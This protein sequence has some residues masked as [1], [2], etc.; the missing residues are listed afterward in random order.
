MIFDAQNL[1]SQAQALTTTAASTNY[2]NLSQVR[3][4]G[5]GEPL[6]L[7]CVVTTA[8]TDTGSDS[9][10]TVALEGDS[11]T[12]FTPDGTENQFIFP[13]L[14]AVGAT[15]ITR[16]DPG[17]APLQYQYIQLKYTMTGGDLT[18]GA[19]TAFLTHDIDKY[20]SY[21]KGYTIS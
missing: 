10:V 6:Y 15:K 12:T 17:S 1:F 11:S 5:T 7:V 8:F 3:D 19:I 13:A 18:T 20:K 4:I 16:L 14:S 9:T 21:A 2:I